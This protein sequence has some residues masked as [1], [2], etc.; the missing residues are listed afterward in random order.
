MTQTFPWTAAEPDLQM[1]LENHSPRPDLW[2]PET[3][4]R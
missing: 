1:I 4:L 3:F 2:L